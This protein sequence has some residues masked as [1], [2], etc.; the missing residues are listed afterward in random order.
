VG[1]DELANLRRIG[2]VIKDECMDYNESEA[3]Q[4]VDLSTDRPE[5]NPLSEELISDETWYRI[6]H[7]YCD[8]TDW[9][10]ED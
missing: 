9:S 8:W 3:R 5:E 2:V 7:E 4:D 10:D 6:L 1:K